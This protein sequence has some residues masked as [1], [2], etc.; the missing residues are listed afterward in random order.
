MSENKQD[1]LSNTVIIVLAVGGGLLGLVA[2][3]GLVAALLIPKLVGT[4]EA[5]R[6]AMCT[7]NLRNLHLACV[8]FADEAG[9][10]PGAGAA[11]P[12]VEGFQE[13]VRKGQLTN[14]KSLICP[15]SNDSLSAMPGLLGN[16]T[17]IPE[18]R[19]EAAARIAINKRGGTCSYLMTNRP[20]SPFDPG[21]LPLIIE[22][23]HAQPGGHPTGAHVLTHDGAIEFVKSAERYQDARSKMAR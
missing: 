21:A 7:V 4:R 20:I 5:A 23:R 19:E 6:G 3:G 1:G 14:L 2:V 18:Q 16:G 22:A 10:F 17:V 9:R 13:L 12:G 15:S 11:E 8:V